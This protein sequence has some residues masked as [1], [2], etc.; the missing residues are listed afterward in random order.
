MSEKSVTQAGNQRLLQRRAERKDGFTEEKR[1]IFLDHLAGCCNVRRSAAAAG[2]SDVTVNY[3]RRRDS[4]FA[5]ACEQA[6]E[7]G[8]Q[9]LE[10]ALLERAARGGDHVP[11]EGAEAVPGPETVDTETGLRLLAIRSRGMGQRT[12]KGGRAPTRVTE[13]ELNE[14]ILA[15]MALLGKRRAKAKRGA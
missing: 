2:V 15:R 4:V 12:G 8:Y 14:A 11:G 3:H 13:K 6:L 9:M 7:T 10:A 1:Q 5:Q